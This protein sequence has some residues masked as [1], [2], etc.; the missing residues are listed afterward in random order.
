MNTR[1]QVEHGVTETIF[2]GLDIIELMIKQGLAEYDARH[3]STT[4]KGINLSLL[5]QEHYSTPTSNIHAIETRVYCENPVNKFSPS[6]GVLQYVHFPEGNSDLR[7]DT[8]V[9]LF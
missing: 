7:V 1:L 8:W 3:S 9:C 6:P 4:S 5:R 2:P